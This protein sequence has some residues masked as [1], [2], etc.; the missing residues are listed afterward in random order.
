[1][2]GYELS[3]ES[4]TGEFLDLAVAEKS[5]QGFWVSTVEGFASEV[6]VD[7][8]VNPTSVG[9]TASGSSI[10]SMT[11]TLGV[12]VSPESVGSMLG[13][14]ELWTMLKRSFSQVMQGTMRLS[15]PD[16]QVLSASMRLAAPIPA[17]E[18]NPHAFSVDN[19]QVDVDLVSESG[20]WFGMPDEGGPT[21]D[22]RLLINTGDITEYLDVEW[23]GSGC[24]VQVDGGRVVDLP[25]VSDPRR[26]STDPG[27]GFKITDPA[28]GRVDVSAWSSMRGRSVPGEILPGRQ[29]VVST[30]G[31]VTVTV[32]PRFLDP[33]R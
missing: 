31:N 25:S 21:A 8:A 27:S 26:L 9:E 2:A 10:P 15:Q 23:S 11:G 12:V 20:V 5:R 16:G 22:G 4:H 18:Y 1:M 13:L 19:L 28:T 6:D 33:W 17:P 14:P 7:T 29:V 30:T 3:W 32:T 24:S